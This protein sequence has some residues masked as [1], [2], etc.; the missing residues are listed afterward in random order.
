MKLRDIADRL[1][2]RLEGD[3]DVD[4]VRVA[5]VHKA[6]PGDLTFVSNA[7]Y[8]S[9]LATTRASAVILGRSNGTAARVP[10]AV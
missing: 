1:Q 10:C 3:S 7:R 9:Q 6:G 8:L 4:I 2:C 5:A